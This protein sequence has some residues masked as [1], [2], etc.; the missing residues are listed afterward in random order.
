MT[1]KIIEENDSSIILLDVQQKLEDKIQN[2]D[3][4]RNIGKVMSFAPDGKTL[5]LARDD[6]LIKSPLISWNVQDNSYNTHILLDFNGQ[7]IQ[8]WKIA[9]TPDG[10]YLIVSTGFSIVVLE[11]DTLKIVAKSHESSDDNSRWDFAIT[12]DGKYVAVPITQTAMVEIYEL[13]ELKLINKWYEKQ[14]TQAA[15]GKLVKDIGGWSHI[16]ASPDGSWITP[17]ANSWNAT[18]DLIVDFWEMPKQKKK[19]Q[20]NIAKLAKLRNMACF[21]AYCIDFSPDNQF[22]VISCYDNTI[23]IIDIKKKK[24]ILEKKGQFVSPFLRFSP[25]GQYLAY[26][27]KHLQIS[28]F[29]SLQEY[30]QIKNFSNHTLGSIAFSPDSKTMAF[31]MKNQPAL[32]DLTSL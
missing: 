8:I 1:S 32:L 29:P 13:P 7:T 18:S 24:L 26:E 17:C 6:S 25:N 22:L 4:L 31:Q 23:R 12:P 16:A 10:K 20:L 14:A 9:H 28:K 21:S 2:R 11:A 3:L 30:I 15:H 19:F 27:D 5:V